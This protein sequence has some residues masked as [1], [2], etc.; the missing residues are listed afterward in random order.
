MTISA[1][2]FTPE[3]REK[4]RLARLGREREAKK[5]AKALGIVEPPPE[6]EPRERP[7]MSRSRS[8]VWSVRV[9]RTEGRRP[10]LV[11]TGETSLHEALKVVDASGVQKLSIMARAKC[12]TA[13]VAQILIAG[14]NQNAEEVARAW[15]RNLLMDSGGSTPRTYLTMVQ[16][17]LRIHGCAGKP[18]NAI[19]RE[20]LH[21]FVNDAAVKESTRNTRMAA[22]K[23]FY[24]HAAG[25]GHVIGNIATTLTINKSLL[26]VEQRQ[27]IPAAPF[28]QEEFE[29]ILAHPMTTRN[30]R[31]FCTMGW[32]LGLRM[33]DVCRFETASMGD[34]FVVLYPQKT[35]RR[36]LLPLND[37]LIGGGQLKAVFDEIRATLRTGQVYCFPALK[38]QYPYGFCGHYA[39]DFKRLMRLVGIEGKT[40]HGFRHAFRLRLSASGKTIEEVADLMGHTDTKVTEGYGRA[41]A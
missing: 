1:R 2:F 38:A 24:R 27:R 37:P 13:D 14:H 21:A 34:D 33:V 36:L 25:C 17:F 40:F 22:I 39:Q 3:M 4:R 28:T 19:T 23:S 20:M 9:P 7:A 15:H 41:S 11:S 35:G 32:W 29:R 16:Q 5:Q 8:G 18:M 12:L 31:W 26:T 6:E 10:Y 30:W